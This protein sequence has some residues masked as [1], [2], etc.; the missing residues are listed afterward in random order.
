MKQLHKPEKD[1]A[2]LKFQ[3]EIFHSYSCALQTGLL[4][5]LHNPNTEYATYDF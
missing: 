4:N 5:Q 3:R 2:A 1:A